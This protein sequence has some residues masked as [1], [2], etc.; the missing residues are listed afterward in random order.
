MAHFAKVLNG[1]VL[2]VIV[3]EQDFIDSYVDTVP[4]EWIQTSYNTLGNEHLLGKTPLRK[5]FAA[6]GG[7]YDNS[8]G[9][10]GFTAPV[11][12]KYFFHATAMIDHYTTMTDYG[13][14][15]LDFTVNGNAAGRE[16]MMPR[17]SGGSFATIENSGIFH[18]V[19]GKTMQVRT[20]QS[21][22]TLANIRND[23]RFF[24]GYLIG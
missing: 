16:R 2:D 21:G 12:G 10:S 24:E 15:F 20:N 3:A 6:V 23:Y 14:L 4:G 1:K 11:T 8:A 5:N 18:M 17:P 7:N 22:G 9:T 19:A 13:Y